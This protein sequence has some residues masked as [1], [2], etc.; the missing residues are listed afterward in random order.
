MNNKFCP[1]WISVP[2][3][4]ILDILMERNISIDEFAKSM[5]MSNLE[6]N[7]LI[8]GNI[9]IKNK[10][11]NKLSNVLGACPK[12]WLTREKQYR[13]GFLNRLIK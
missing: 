9:K 7:D 10:I 2:G 4:T 12:F 3:D 1:D 8:L 6:V 5:Q 13:S 11:A